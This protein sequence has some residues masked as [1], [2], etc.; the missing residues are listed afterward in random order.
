[1]RAVLKQ[2]TGAYLIIK[3]VTLARFATAKIEAPTTTLGII[4][5]PKF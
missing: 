2:S 5:L 1:M 3:G 4:P